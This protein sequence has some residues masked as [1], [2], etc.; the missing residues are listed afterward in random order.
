MIYGNLA[1]SNQHHVVTCYHEKKETTTNK[2]ANDSWGLSQHYCA[3]AFYNCELQWEI[4]H[5]T[6]T[7]P[8]TMECHYK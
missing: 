4:P 2:F 6:C 3:A 8:S 1:I 7:I 5:C